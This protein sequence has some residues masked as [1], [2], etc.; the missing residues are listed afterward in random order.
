MTEKDPDGLILTSVAVMIV[1]FVL[2]CL[3]VAYRLI[4]LGSKTKLQKSAEKHVSD[5]STTPTEKEAAAIAIALERYMKEE[6]HDKES[7]II[8]IKRR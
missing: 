4:G 8:T 2:L 3:T 7:Y 1:F 6:Q 5:K